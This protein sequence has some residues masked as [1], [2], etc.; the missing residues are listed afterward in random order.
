MIVE[1]GQILEIDLSNQIF[2]WVFAF[3]AVACIVVFIF[4]KI[5]CYN[6]ARHD[7]GK[8]FLCFIYFFIYKDYRFDEVPV[9]NFDKNVCLLTS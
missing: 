5:S 1:N 4:N 7:E 9:F 6:D 8:M 2:A 3:G